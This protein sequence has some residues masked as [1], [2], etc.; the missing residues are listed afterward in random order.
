MVYSAY[1]LYKNACH[2]FALEVTRHPAMSPKRILSVDL[3]HKINDRLSAMALISVSLLKV[4]RLI[5]RGVALIVILIK[6]QQKLYI[7]TR[8]KKNVVARNFK[9]NKPWMMG[10]HEFMGRTLL[11]LQI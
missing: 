3:H 6:V 8:L 9:Y 4:R 7:Y 11:A 1:S 2:Y 5:K 10:P